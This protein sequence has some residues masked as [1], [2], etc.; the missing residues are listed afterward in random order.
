MLQKNWILIEFS[1]SEEA[2]RDQNI[3]GDEG[4]RAANELT[5]TNKSSTEKEFIRLSFIRLSFIRPSFLVSSRSAKKFR[6]K[7]A[8]APGPS[9]GTQTNAAAAA[10]A[11]GA[12]GRFLIHSCSFCC[13][14][15]QRAHEGGGVYLSARR[16]SQEQMLE[17]FIASENIPVW[18]R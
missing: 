13:S 2:E 10:G 8:E 12:G 16:Q 18:K 17:L 14:R 6:I 3:R 4:G 1:S 11:R 15:K 7:V 5:Y 9:L